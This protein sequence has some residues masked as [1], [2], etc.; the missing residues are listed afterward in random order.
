MISVRLAGQ[1][2]VCGKNLK[3]VIFWDT[4]NIVNGT[5]S[6]G[7]VK[8]KRKRTWQTEKEVGRQHQGMDRPGVHQV[9]EGSLERE[10]WQKLVVKSIFGAQ[11]T[12]AVKG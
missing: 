8:A 3:G 7:T 10:E 12:L 6:Q 5:I 1:P 11:T 9:P 4:L 2:S